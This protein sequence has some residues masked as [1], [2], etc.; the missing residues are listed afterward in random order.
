MISCYTFS[1]ITSIII[2]RFDLDTK[3]P[4]LC[5]HPIESFHQFGIQTCDELVVIIIFHLIFS[6]RK[7]FQMTLSYFCPIKE[8]RFWCPWVTKGS[9]IS[10]NDKL[11]RRSIHQDRSGKLGWKTFVELLM[12]NN[13]K[14]N[15]GKESQKVAF[16]WFL[17]FSF[18]KSQH[19]LLNYQGY[20]N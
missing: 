20:N 3:W 11:D 2:K 13:S 5:H 18:V 19:F 9:V 12:S 15:S 4:R 6:T 1:C 10:A 16:I 7:S 8:H 14:Q 17:V